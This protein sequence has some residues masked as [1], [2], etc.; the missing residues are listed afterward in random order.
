MGIGAG[1][2]SRVDSVKLAVM[3]AETAGLALGKNR[4]C[5]RRVFPFSRRCRRCGRSWRYGGDSAGRI[6]SGRRRDRRCEQA[7]HGHGL[8]GRA[9]LPP[10]T[11]R[12]DVS[13]ASAFFFCRAFLAISCRGFHAVEANFGHLLVVSIL[14]NFGARSVG[15]G[16]D[17]DQRLPAGLA[18]EAFSKIA[19]AASTLV[20]LKIDDGGLLPGRKRRSE[21]AETK[22]DPVGTFREREQFQHERLVVFHHAKQSR[23]FAPPSGHPDLLGNARAPNS[24]PFSFEPGE[25][26]ESGIRVL[27]WLR[28]KQFVDA[29]AG[30]VCM[31]RAPASTLRAERSRSC[32][33]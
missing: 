11:A 2:M 24:L 31:T 16:I 22:F 3:K 20:R 32:P 10:L 8:Y 14:G 18:A 26:G 23:N 7:G 28:R 27:R 30:S 12:I 1:Q 4:R 25:V 15:V 13:A 17:T 5:I 33:Y 6:G 21:M 29:F 19:L 9:A